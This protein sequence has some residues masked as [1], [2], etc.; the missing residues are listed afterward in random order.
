MDSPASLGRLRQALAAGNPTACLALLA[1]LREQV[2]PATLLRPVLAGCHPG[3]DP[4]FLDP[5]LVPATILLAPRFPEL[6]RECCL[7]PLLVEMAHG[8]DLFAFVVGP[9]TQVL[10]GE[11]PLYAGLPALNIGCYQQLMQLSRAGRRWLRT[12]SALDCLARETSLVARAQAAPPRSTTDQPVTALARWAPSQ[13]D[14]LLAH[15]W[16]WIQGP[17]QPDG[18]RLAQA[19]VLDGSVA[20]GDASSAAHLVL[21]AS[22]RVLEG[23][24]HY[25]LWNGTEPPPASWLALI[26][27]LAGLRDRPFCQL[28]Q[29]SRGVCEI[30]PLRPSAAPA[31]LAISAHW[32]A[33]RQPHQVRA[34]LGHWL[35]GP[36]VAQKPRLDPDLLRHRDQ[37]LRPAALEGVLVLAAT[38]AQVADL[39]LVWLRQRACQLAAEGGFSRAS[40]L[41]LAGGEAGDPAQQLRLLAGQEEAGAGAQA[42]LALVGPHDQ[43]APGAWQQLAGFLGWHPHHLCCTD[44]EVLWCQSPPRYGQRQFVAQTTAFRLLSRGQLAGLV[45]LAAT[46]LSGLHLQPAY[47]SLHALLKDLGLQ[48]LER[49]GEIKALPQAL[50]RREPTSNP[51][52][53]SISTPDQRHLFSGEQLL[54]LEQLTRRR[55]TAWMVPGGSLVSGPRQGSFRLHYC[56]A[57]ADL[58]SVI[59]PF[60]DQASLTRQCVVSLLAQAGPTPLEL[61][62]VD[63]GSV[64]PEAT[65]LAEELAPLAAARGVNLIALRDDSPFNFA[66]LNNRA[67]QFCSGNF[68]LFLNNDICF[69]SPGP[70]EELLHPFAMSTTAA[71]SARLLFEDNTIQHHG[72]AAAARQPHDILS[73]GKGL[74]PGIDTEPFAVLELQEQWSAATAACLLIRSSEFDQLEGFD[75]SFVV[76]YNDVDL[77]WRLTAA[78]RAVIVTP[79]PRIIHAESKSRGNDFSGEKRNRLARESAALRGRYPRRFQQGDP[80]YHRFLGPASHRFEPMALPPRPLAPARERFLS[81]WVREGFKPGGQRPFLIYVHWD[82]RGQVRPDVLEQ[83]RAYRAHADLAF[84]SAAPALRDRPGEMAALRKLCDVVLVRQNEGYDFGSWQA[85]LAFCKPYL[86]N[87]SRLI[88]TNDSCYGPLNP[89]DVLFERLAASRADVVGLTESTAIR[90]HLQSYFVAYGARLLRSSLF[91]LFWEQIGIWSSKLDL[92]M[93]YEVGWSGVLADAGFTQEALFLAGQHGNVTHTHWRELLEELQFPFLKTELLRLNPIRQDIDA[94]PQVA[95]ACNP[96]VAAMISDHLAISP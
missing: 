75:E 87:A 1:Q 55:A 92:V 79:A 8:C 31:L 70:I 6:L 41:Q 74:R 32:L 20:V 72:L 44:E 95:A 76:A 40:V 16:I 63:N 12:S 56:A 2:Y 58:V 90:S 51:T 3:L 28:G 57:A 59:I 43:L 7:D 18:A 33:R 23:G 34:F 65:A 86:R 5:D 15:P 21:D 85:G 54:E 36:A 73:P 27:G 50:L 53:L 80:L 37:P 47:G 68:L 39:G 77:C 29:T 67:R 38:A 24:A 96:R 52:L 82:A 35:A 61:V 10:R 66:A 62:L 88:L 84:V 22:R 69:A 89:L 14:G 11:R 17:G 48:W 4:V 26:R 9:L 25:L 45:S 78:G 42:V 91:W 46:G 83:L 60:R 93:A 71:V 64:E 81:A 13:L 30:L 94:W 49:G 19:L